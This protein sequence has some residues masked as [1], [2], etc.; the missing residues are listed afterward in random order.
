MS[1]ICNVLEE[2]ASHKISLILEISQ[3]LDTYLLSYLKW[4]SL[5]QHLDHPVVLIMI[6][7]VIVRRDATCMSDIERHCTPLT[8]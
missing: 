4:N 5:P 1:G 3:L 7:V 6:L 2:D 8:K